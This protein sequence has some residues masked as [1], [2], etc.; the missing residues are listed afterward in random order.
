MYIIWMY[1]IIATTILGLISWSALGDDMEIRKTYELSHPLAKVYEAW[2][3]SE[4][5][6][7]PATGMDIDPKVGGHYRLIMDTPDFKTGNDGVFH[8]LA[9]DERVVYTWQWQGDDEV[10]VI[11]VRFEETDKGT[12]IQ[13]LHSGFQSEDSRNRHDSG[14]D[15]YIEGFRTFLT[16]V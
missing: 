3:S 11:D 9:P 4:T 2:I 15:S 13:L 6:I 16:A 1:K 8:L 5:V 14:W 7:A 10:T 12:R